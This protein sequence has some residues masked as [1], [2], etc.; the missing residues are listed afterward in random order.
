[1]LSHGLHSRTEPQGPSGNA[2]NNTSFIHS[3]PSLP[4]LPSPLTVL[5]LES[6]SQGL[7]LRPSLPPPSKSGVGSRQ[8]GSR[9]HVLK[10]SS[11]DLSCLQHVMCAAL[12][13]TPG[14]QG[15]SDKWQQL[16]LSGVGNHT[17]EGLSQLLLSKTVIPGSL[18]S[19]IPSRRVKSFKR[20]ESWD[21]R[22][23]K[24][25]QVAFLPACLVPHLHLSHRIPHQWSFTLCLHTSRDRE[26]TTAQGHF[27]NHLKACLYTESISA[28]LLAWLCHLGGSENPVGM[29]E[30]RPGH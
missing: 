18:V 28:S 7:I 3:F 29:G 24:S 20:T 16:M 25:L 2:L 15:Q 6:L 22:A 9:I 23:S 1:M 8:L 26:L 14:I 21:S 12:I 19:I 27:C 5:A 11:P 30:Q 13:M 17:F 10:H 4:Y